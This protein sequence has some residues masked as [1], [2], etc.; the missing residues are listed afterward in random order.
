MAKRIYTPIL[1]LLLFVLM[2]TPALAVTRTGISD[3]GK[4]AFMWGFHYKGSHQSISTITEQVIDVHGDL[5]VS[6]ALVDA[7]NTSRS[8]TTASCGTEDD[9]LNP[10]YSGLARSDHFFHTSGYVDSNFQTSKSF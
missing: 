3:G 8:G 1:V 5:F 7:C 4:I 10:F 9:F 2:T 6:G